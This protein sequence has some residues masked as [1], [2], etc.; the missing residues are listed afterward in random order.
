MKNKYAC[1]RLQQ[2]IYL[3]NCASDTVAA[4]DTDTHEVID[5]PIVVGQFPDSIAFAP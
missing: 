1:D 2:R 5:V 4:I 3:A